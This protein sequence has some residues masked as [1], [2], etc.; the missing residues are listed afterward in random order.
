LAR[1]DPSNNKIIEKRFVLLKGR[2]D[3]NSDCLKGNPIYDGNTLRA[4]PVV[5]IIIKEPYG[6]KSIGNL[7]VWNFDAGKWDAQRIAM[8]RMIE[9]KSQQYPSDLQ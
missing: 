6:P 4:D 1:L 9:T 7:D 2:K 8:G 5:N 3:F